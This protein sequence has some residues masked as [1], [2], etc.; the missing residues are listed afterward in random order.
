MSITKTTMKITRKS[1]YNKKSTCKNGKKF[2]VV[3]QGL[4]KSTA[5]T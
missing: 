1:D 4:N 5:L 2:L 3:E